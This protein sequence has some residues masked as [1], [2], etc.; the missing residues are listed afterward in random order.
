MVQEWRDQYKQIGTNKKRG[1]GWNHKINQ[2]IA[3]GAQ[4]LILGDK[5]KDASHTKA[6]HLIITTP[7]HPHNACRPFG[8]PPG[9]WD[10][11]ESFHLPYDSSILFPC[12]WQLASGR[13]PLS[14]SRSH[15]CAYGR[16]LF[17]CLVSSLRGGPLLPGLC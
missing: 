9:P 6:H 11:P 10:L 17:Q 14:V 12:S 7:S 4:R 2:P 3:E 15:W 13:H 8:K 5:R 16:P 1:K